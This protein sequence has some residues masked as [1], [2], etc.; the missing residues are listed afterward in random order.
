MRLFVTILFLWTLGIIQPGID[1]LGSGKTGDISINGTAMLDKNRDQIYPSNLEYLNNRT[2]IQLDYHPEVKKYIDYYV[3]DNPQMLSV[4]AGRSNYY[5]PIFDEILAKHNLPLELKN[6]TVVE[7]ALNP[8]AVSKSGATGLWQ[9][10]FHTSKMFHLNISSYIDERRDPVN[11]TEAACEFLS[12]LYR[13]F[14]DWQLAITAYNCGPGMV[15]SAI[16]K[17]GSTNYWE[18]R[19]Y[20]TTEAQN[21]YPKFVAACYM[22]SFHE[23]HG[24]KAK[25]YNYTY[26]EVETVNIKKSI[27]YKQIANVIHIKEADIRLLNPI[28]KQDFIP[29]YNESAKVVLPKAVAKEFYLNEEKIYAVRYKNMDYRDVRAEAGNTDGKIRMTYHV[30]KGE[31]FHQIAMDHGCTLYDIMNWNGMTSKHLSAGQDLTIYVDK[32]KH[33]KNVARLKP[34]KE[35][36]K[37]L[38]VENH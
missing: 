6:L 30:K 27:W 5:F 11:S 24:I 18:I 23:N 31:Y 8:F 20:L 10:L 26:D 15:E 3:L 4:I 32:E 17:A 21:Y 33:N 14:N 38:L 36:D 28:Y 13:I 34:F 25:K 29:V 35:E 16:E 22:L 37:L 9:F 12:Y 1:M 2:P 7:S 19:K